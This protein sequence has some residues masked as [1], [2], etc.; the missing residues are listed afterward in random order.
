[1]SDDMEKAAEGFWGRMNHP[2]FG[3]FIASW[4]ACNW[5][6]IYLLIRGLATAKE[7]IVEINSTYFIL[8]RIWQLLFIP[9]VVTF[10]YLFFG[11]YFKKWVSVHRT[12]VEARE[13][14]EESKARMEFPITKSEYGLLMLKNNELQDQMRNQV[15]QQKSL[16]D[17]YE[18]RLQTERDQKQSIVNALS[19]VKNKKFSLKDGSEI[20]AENLVQ[21]YLAQSKYLKECQDKNTNLEAE[22]IMAR[23]EK[24]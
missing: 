2:V 18:Q 23:E 15:M 8:S 22:L 14:F 19:L 1:M 3:A 6:S 21:Q 20:T 13:K 5:E 11:P 4:L 17:N 12:K 9:C 24:K 7:T 16:Q 10:F